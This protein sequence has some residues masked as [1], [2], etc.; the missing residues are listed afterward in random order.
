MDIFKPFGDVD[1]LLLSKDDPTSTV[2]HGHGFVQYQTTAAAMQAIQQLNNLDLAGNKLLVRP[3]LPPTVSPSPSLSVSLALGDR[4]GS[5]RSSPSF[6]N[7][8]RQKRHLHASN[9]FRPP[10][11]PTTASR[12]VASH[13]CVTTQRGPAR[14]L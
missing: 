2:H 1:F 7:S 14:C 5:T 10:S 8:T 13:A 4:G 3:P 6:S 11:R 12:R 9:R